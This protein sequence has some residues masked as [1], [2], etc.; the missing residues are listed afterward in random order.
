MERSIF[1]KSQREIFLALAIL[2]DGLHADES[3]DSMRDVHD[4]IAFLQIKE[5]INGPTRGDLGRS[6]PLFIT[7]KQ[8][9]MPK[10]RD[11]SLPRMCIRGFVFRFS[12]SFI[13]HK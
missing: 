6:A 7:M 8:L 9:V 2:G 12:K 13:P 10:H 11:G 4:V 3:R 1:R 5:R